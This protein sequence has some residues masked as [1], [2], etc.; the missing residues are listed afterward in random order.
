VRVALLEAHTHFDI[1]RKADFSC[2]SSL[3]LPSWLDS[4]FMIM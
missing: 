2:L 4:S 3:K 1:F